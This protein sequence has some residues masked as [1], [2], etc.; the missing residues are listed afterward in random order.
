MSLIYSQSEQCCMQGNAMMNSVF[1][2]ACSAQTVITV[3]RMQTV[4][5]CTSCPTAFHAAGHQLPLVSGCPQQQIHL[6]LHLTHLHSVAPD[7]VDKLIMTVCAAFIFFN[8]KKKM[9]SCKPYY[10]DHTLF[11]LA[12][13]NLNKHFPC[14]AYSPNNML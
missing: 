2:G 5:S 12:G 13:N 14:L 11:G 6:Q 3:T 10:L 7:C 9:P 8:T 4:Y 1:S